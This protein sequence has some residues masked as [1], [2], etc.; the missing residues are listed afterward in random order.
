MTES[1]RK[2]YH[3]G[4]LNY[5]MPQLLAVCAWILMT[6]LSLNLLA[7]K[8]VPTL[9]PLL[10]DKYQI[11]SATIALILSTIPSIMNF[12]IC[13]I[14]STVSD[15]TR[16]RFGRRIPY[17]AI[18]TPFV[19]LFMILIA[20]EGD[21]ALFIQ[22]TFLTG[23]P[24]AS[25]ALWVLAVLFIFFQLAYLVPGAVVYYLYADVVPKQFIGTFVAT[26]AFFGTGVTFVFN[27]YILEPTSQ[28]PKFWFSVIGGAYFLSYLLLCL[29]VREG[30][31]PPVDDRI[32]AK[33]GILHKAFD[34][35]KLYFTQCYRHRIFVMLFLATGLTQAST[36][37]RNMFNLLFAT[38]DLHMTTGEYGRV[39][40]IGALVAAVIVLPMGKI[41]DKIHPIR[42]FF[43]SG[44]VVIAFNIWGYFYV[45]DAKSF[46]VT[47][48]AISLIYAIQFLSTTPLLIALVP[49]DKYGQFASANSM[50]NCM[51]MVGASYLGGL[52]I[53]W[54]GYRMIFIWD[55]ALTVIATVTL[56]VVYS[57]WKKYGGQKNY[58]PP[59]VDCHCHS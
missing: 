27:Y 28:N 11:S 55:F 5:T 42:V 57:D 41:M 20:F 59:K 1:L 43:F 18:S 58:A 24:L 30:K 6:V 39:I 36:L 22:R 19:V 54:F 52:C 9:M 10:F 50:I 40:A 25:I 26:I 14:L 45:Y 33:E 51:V 17:L 31:Y 15:K 12:F 7:Y 2:F 32:D 35:V 44:L 53:D 49:G 21:I 56:L 3:A 46:T 23:V 29:L 48:I 47:G 37:C 4:T 34:Y 16:T 13:P 8:M 38:K